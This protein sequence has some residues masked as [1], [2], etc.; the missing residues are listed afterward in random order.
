MVYE[1]KPLH[2]RKS[3]LNKKLKMVW[4]NKIKIGVIG[5]N[6]WIKLQQSVS[7]QTTLVHRW[8]SC[9]RDEKFV[10]DEDWKWFSSVCGPNSRAQFVG[11][12]NNCLWNQIP[13][14]KWTYIN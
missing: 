10:V 12:F 9:K 14:A 13:W 8:K 3:V 5:L 11:K 2:T 1:Y 6:M 4:A 7:A